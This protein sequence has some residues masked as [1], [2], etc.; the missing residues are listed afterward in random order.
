MQGASHPCP[1]CSRIYTSGKPSDRAV[2]GLTWA[3]EVTCTLEPHW[4]PSSLFTAGMTQTSS[5][6]DALGTASLP[7]RLLVFRVLETRQRYGNFYRTMVLS[8]VP[9]G[10][11][12][13][14]ASRLEAELCWAWLWF[15]FRQER[16]V[17]VQA[18]SA[19]S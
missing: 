12:Q 2:F 18:A 7:P 16:P 13:W 11:E 14:P 10:V 4:P 9:L 15:L 6:Q 3:C 1:S 5:L 8:P 17:R 19:A